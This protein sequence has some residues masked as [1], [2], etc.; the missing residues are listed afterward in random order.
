MSYLLLQLGENEG[1]EE[2]TDR[3]GAANEQYPVQS[4]AAQ[5]GCVYCFCS[6]HSDISIL[7]THL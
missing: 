5:P 6:I 2:I 3:S 1:L 7:E 4:V